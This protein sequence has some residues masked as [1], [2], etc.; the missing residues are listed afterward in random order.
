[1]QLNNRNG[2][3]QFNFDSGEELHIDINGDKENL[4]T[5]PKLGG[6]HGCFFEGICNEILSM[7]CGECIFVTQPE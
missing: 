1:M 6:C 7:K 2:K 3:L 4:I 5:V